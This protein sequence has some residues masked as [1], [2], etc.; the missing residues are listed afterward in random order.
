M[1]KRSHE[2]IFVITDHRELNVFNRDELKSKLDS[3]GQS[4]ETLL[5][6]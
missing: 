1:I 4:Y 3:W 6:A 5:S 2:T